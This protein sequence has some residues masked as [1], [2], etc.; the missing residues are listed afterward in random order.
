MASENRAMPSRRLDRVRDAPAI[1]AGAH[2]AILKKYWRDRELSSS[3][4]T[5]FRRGLLSSSPRMRSAAV[6]SRQAS[7][8]RL[9][10]VSE[11]LLVSRPELG[12]DVAEGG[13][14]AA[15]R[16][17]CRNSTISAVG[18]PGV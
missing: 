17:D 5:A 11:G 15:P 14:Y 1:K 7:R 9:D 6:C 18:A 2:R 10:A 12:S 8:R 4:L 3:G 13:T 16:V